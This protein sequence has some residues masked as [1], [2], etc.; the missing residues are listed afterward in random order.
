MTSPRTPLAF[1]G[2]ALL[3]LT[4]AG[5]GGGSG[6]GSPGSGASGSGASGSGASGAAS[7]G[8]GTLA[9]GKT[10][11]MAISTD[12]GNLDPHQTVLSVTRQVD[13]FLYARLV[14]QAADGKIVAGLAEKWEADTSKATFTL[15]NGITCADGTPLTASDV[16]ANI[17]Y[18]GDAKNKSPLAG[19]FVP[20]G[21][22]AKG[23][24]GARTVTVTSGKPDAFLLVNFGYVPIVCGKGLI[25]RSLLAKGGAG[26]G[27]FTVSDIVP[28]DHYTFTRRKDF[29][30]GPGDWKA[31]QAGLPDT[32]TLKVIANETTAANL[33]VSGGVNVA[34]VAGPDQDRLA[35]QKLFHVDSLAP[36]GQLWF[37]QAEGHPTAEAPVRRALV[38]ALD[39]NKVGQVLTSGK[40][41]P[42]QGMVTVAPNPCRT[43]TV[44][45][46]VPAF[47]NAAAKSGLDGAGWVAGADGVRAK[48]GKKLAITVL[49]VTSVA[50]A[51]PAAELIQQMLK[52]I[53]VAATLKGVDST[54]L[55]EVLFSTGAWDISMGP[56][57][58]GLP[59][60][61]VPFLSG[62]VPP[63]G[64]NFAHVKNADFDA[65]VKTASGKVGNAGCSDWAAAE[66]AAIKAADIVPYYNTVVPIFG[67]KTQFVADDGVDPASIRMYQ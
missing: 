12:P 62:P 57:T 46:N 15:R 59:S 53:G 60:Q 64:V 19:L 6:S 26:T 66:V 30:W 44:T 29:T 16:A 34:T 36:L 67:K 24:D 51:V 41:K 35:A 48:G 55:S 1:L 31:D 8:G 52:E 13:R 39:L 17:N 28:S 11:T 14:E 18:I 43:D 40:G 4:A 50:S 33:L 38:Q 27:M 47:D 23:D 21:S 5:C 2:I 54:G 49:Y 32:V 56:L 3:G 20:A 22:K 9:N 65:A 10:F 63:Q 42:S 7:P 61:V 58:V 45:G 25:D 37:N